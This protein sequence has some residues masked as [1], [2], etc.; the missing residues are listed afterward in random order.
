MPASDSSPSGTTP[1]SARPRSPR[2]S[3]AGCR[4][5]GH[6]VEVLTGIPNYPGG[7]FYPGY[8]LRP[9][10]REVRDGIT[11]HRA[12]LYASHDT[13]ATHRAATFLSF[14]AAASAVGLR[15]LRHVDSVLVYSSPATAGLPALAFHGLRRIPFVVHVQDLWPQSVT[16]S[17]L[18]GGVVGTTGGT[19]PEPPLRHRLPPRRVD[20]RHL[21]R[22]GRAHRRPRRGRAQ[23]R[24]R[25]ELGRRVALLPGRTRCPAGARARPVPGLHG[26]VRR[27]PRRDPGA[28]RRR[29]CRR[30][31]PR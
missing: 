14:A 3:P 6:Q 31:A 22:D 16:A 21:A 20:R 10:Q 15:A 2:R 25:R 23:D 17:G 4:P 19:G 8:R 12:P 9:Y 27:Q 24:R 7:R 26:H 28:R 29:G 5:Y 13:R 18:L 11:V 30:P 1:R